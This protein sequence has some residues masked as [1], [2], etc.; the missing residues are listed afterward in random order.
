MF[1]LHSRKY[2][3]S[4]PG[5]N[6]RTVGE[7]RLQ[8]SAQTT[9]THF[10][11][12]QKRWIQVKNTYCSSSTFVSSLSSLTYYTVSVFKIQRRWTH[13]YWNFFFFCCCCWIYLVKKLSFD[14]LWL[15]KWNKAVV[16]N[17]FWQW[18]NL[19]V[20]AQT[21]KQSQSFY[22]IPFYSQMQDIWVSCLPLY[23]TWNIWG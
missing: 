8:H 18:C 6:F 10:Y 16:T 12:M 3:H 1:F 13:T 20:F 15:I 21:H 7:T 19:I 4:W 9:D 17:H 11:T 2:H 14:H 5:V 22:S 23:R